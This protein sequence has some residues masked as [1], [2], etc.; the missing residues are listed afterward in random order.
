MANHC[1]AYLIVGAGLAGAKAIEGIR[2]LDRER[3]ITMIGTEDHLPYDRPRR[4]RNSVGLSAMRMK[5]EIMTLS[6]EKG[7]R[8]PDEGYQGYQSP[9][10]SLAQS[11]CDGKG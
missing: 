1:C 2:E 5:M 9:P 11:L 3:S 8:N 4:F 10:N 7:S 6:E